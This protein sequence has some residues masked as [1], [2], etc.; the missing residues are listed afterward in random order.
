MLFNILYC[1]SILGNRVEM[2]N[3]YRGHKMSLW[4]NLIPQLHRPGEGD[5][6]SMRHHHFQEEG[7]QYYDGMYTKTLDLIQFKS[8]N[9]MWQWLIMSCVNRFS[10]GADKSKTVFHSRIIAFTTSNNGSSI[11]TTIHPFT[12][13]I[14]HSPASNNNG[15]SS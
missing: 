9:E 14:R 12:T 3:H 4:L 10:T 7:D 6:I 13:K 15:M 8:P 5:D 11:T 2:N 1:S